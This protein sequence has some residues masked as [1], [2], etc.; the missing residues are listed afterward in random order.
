MRQYFAA[1]V[2]AVAV[3]AAAAAAYDPDCEDSVVAPP[4][5]VAYSAA[6]GAAVAPPPAPPVATQAG[7][8]AITAAANKLGTIQSGVVERLKSRAPAADN[9][10]V[11]QAVLPTV[12]FIALAALP[13]A[14]LV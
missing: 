6:P 4:A 9:A 2:V 13:V 10:A 14:F 11:A 12:A 3:V 5:V 1:M 7:P 8:D